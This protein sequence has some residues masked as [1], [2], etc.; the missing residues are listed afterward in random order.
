MQIS[1][2]RNFKSKRPESSTLE[3]IAEYIRTDRSL[4]QITALYRKDGSKT[5]KEESPL[6]AVAAT[7]SGGKS[8]GD[9]T[10]MTG[11]SLVDLDHVA[12]E[13]MAGIRAKAIADP[14]TVLCYTTISGRGLRI[15]FSYE[16]DKDYDLSQ[17]LGFYSLAF[18][19]GNAHYERLL[20][21]EADR[22]C[23]NVNRLS[24][25]A[26]DPGAYFN[27][28]AT[29]FGCDEIML[30]AKDN[31]SRNNLARQ[32]QRI[33]DYYD[34]VIAPKLKSQNK[35]YAP[36]SH[37]EYVMLT[38]YMMARRRYNLESVVQWAVR[39]FSD[40]GDTEQV[41]RS[42][43]GSVAEQRKKPQRRESDMPGAA[44]VDDIKDFLTPR[45]ALRHNVITGRIEYIML[46]PEG[47]D[48]EGR[49]DTGQKWQ[50]MTDRAV[51][52]IWAEMSQTMK[53]N[54]QD[55]IRVME[56]DFTPDHNPFLDYLAT[57]PPWHEG[58]PDYIAQLAA[59]VEVKDD[60]KLSQ[61][62]FVDALR[63]WLVAMLASWINEDVVNN[64]ILVLIGEQG[65]YKTTWFQYLL[66]PQLQQYFYTKTNS[67]RMTK[68]DMLVLS[69]YALVCSEE[70]D[71]MRPAELNQL[72]AAVTMKSTNERAAYARFHETRKHIASFCGTGNN[73]QFLTDPTGNRRWLPF[74]VV[75]I[76]S[77]REHP[78]NYTGIFSQ[79]LAL[80][81]SGF[82]YWFSKE[83]LKIQAAH[84][85]FFESP[86]L[87]RELVALYFR[88][89]RNGE[90]AM[91]VTVSRVMEITACAGIVQRLNPVRIGMAFSELGFD[92]LRSGGNR[93]YLVV[94]RTKEEIQLLLGNV[95]DCDEEFLVPS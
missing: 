72:K 91:F 1:C 77:P 37:N 3:A 58:D 32:V 20:G 57:L 42:C 78:F 81:R 14:H 16:P 25:L 8:K 7:F 82:H 34:R 44:T 73:A 67:G 70:L 17:Q 33:Q 28:D 80:L 12:V 29:P 27:A 94:Q 68:D 51:N 59:T 4:A 76:R 71:T 47:H 88:R 89:P 15:I 39:Q 64:V 43:Y 66:P 6:F 30:T 23:K 90:R 45:I 40:Y 50:T 60:G 53:V 93:G 49:E 62:L 61:L 24:G 11:L 87:E 65:S 19:H 13:R 41:I 92:C 75:S 31:G 46:S 18:A 85:K 9:I 10:E 55:I 63:K 52:T 22:Q 36:G 56:S 38:G 5:I 54:V 74:E 26:Y 35:V 83:E 21:T 2:F 79:M 84:N 95:A 69:Q 86:N 48:E